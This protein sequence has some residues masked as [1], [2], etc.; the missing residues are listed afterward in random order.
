[1]QILI[2][3]IIYSYFFIEIKKSLFLR[4]LNYK[5]KEVTI[6]KGP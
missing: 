4:D 3:L 6:A 5:P 1:M 2:F